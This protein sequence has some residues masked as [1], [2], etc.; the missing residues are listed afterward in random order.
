[1]A[2]ALCSVMFAFFSSNFLT[3]IEYDLKIRHLAREIHIVSPSIN[4]QCSQSFIHPRKHILKNTRWR[5]HYGYIIQ[6]S[7]GILYNVLAIYALWYKCD[8]NIVVIVIHRYFLMILGL[9][10]LGN[11]WF[12]KILL[13]MGDT[14]LLHCVWVIISNN[15]VKTM[16][17]IV[18]VCLHRSAFL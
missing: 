8:F 14:K 2:V 3:F 6:A 12:V 1:M 5:M 17:S 16:W 9:R 7:R 10:Y 4:I 13:C 18:K 11:G 15:Y